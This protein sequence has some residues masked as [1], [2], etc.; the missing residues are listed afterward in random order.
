MSGG[1]SEIVKK[2]IICPALPTNKSRMDLEI[3]LGG[4]EYWATKN[5]GVQKE[6]GDD[7]SSYK[8]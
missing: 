8:I 5:H 4:A 7:I 6:T 1:E 2:N 3:F